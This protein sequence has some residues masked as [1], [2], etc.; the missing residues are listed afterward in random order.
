MSERPEP[1][2]DEQT[3]TI[4]G[5]PLTISAKREETTCSALEGGEPSEWAVS[6]TVD[7]VS[8]RMGTT[9]KT[10]KSLPGEVGPT[11]QNTG[12]RMS[13]AEADEI[14]E[15]GRE[16]AVQA[17]AEAGSEPDD[18]QQVAPVQPSDERT[19][20]LIE[21][22]NAIANDGMDAGMCRT[23]AQAALA[24]ITAD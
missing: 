3:I 12:L 4:L 9:V 2:T 11:K 16:K 5:V 10:D 6:L 18:A 22:L 13:V 1:R 20:R 19:A 14:I 8:A 21:A 7:T 17:V 15:R 23:V 24:D